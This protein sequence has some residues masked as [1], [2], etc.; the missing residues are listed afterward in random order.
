MLIATVVCSARPQCTV[1][2][3]G[4]SLGYLRK[5]L[6]NVPERGVAICI[7]TARS[8]TWHGVES[9]KNIFIAVSII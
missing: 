2:H 4:T 8:G 6:L 3:S 1:R 7:K 5:K 9:V